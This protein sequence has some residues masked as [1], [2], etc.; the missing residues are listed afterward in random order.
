MAENGII[1]IAVG[2]K[3]YANWAA[4]MAVSIRYHNPNLPIAVIVDENCKRNFL[5]EE[6][7]KLF[8]YVL[9]V[10]K[11]H[12]F[13]NSEF[14]PGL[15]K[16]NLNN[17]TPFKKTMFLDA[18]GITIKPLDGLFEMCKG[19]DVASQVNSISTAQDETWP[20]QWMNL[21]NTRK[22]YEL[23]DN[24][25]LP[26]INS[27]FIYWEKSK[28]SDAFF[29]TALECFIPDYKTSWGKAFPDELAFNVAACKEG[30]D[31]SISEEKN[32]PV[33]FL[34]SEGI[35]EQ[36][37]VIGLYGET[38]N[39]FYGTYKLYEKHSH[40]YWRGLMGRTCPYKYGQMMKKKFVLGGRLLV[41]KHFEIP[42]KDA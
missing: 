16:L 22:Y 39:K 36:T 7:E 19:N 9:D 26:E 29:K 37:F 3:A 17:Y 4:N 20:C 34:A 35:K 38:S 30:L 14:S 21:E 41:N 15:L 24:F 1:L 25:N 40:T 23:G 5:R 18:D 6:L 28:K 13:S 11:E 32:V 12:L 10:K 42:K 2:D 27:S 8:D 33:I 31:L